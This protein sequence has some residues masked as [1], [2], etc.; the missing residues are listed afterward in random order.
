M[1]RSADY[2]DDHANKRPRRENPTGDSDPFRPSLQ[3]KATDLLTNGV[4]ESGFIQ[5]TVIMKWPTVSGRVRAE[6]EVLEDGCTKRFAAAFAGV[7]PAFFGS[8]GLT[9]EIGDTLQL[10]LKEASLEI[11]TPIKPRVLPV[12]LSYTNGVCLRFLTKKTPPSIGM[13]VDYWEGECTPYVLH[14]L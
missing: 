3:R 8:V 13:V 2:S 12:K 14:F 1:K 7:C 10:C 11:I 9:F 5:A 6:F 4:D